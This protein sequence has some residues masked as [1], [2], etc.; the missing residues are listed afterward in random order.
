[1][2]NFIEAIHKGKHMTRS[3]TLK[4]IAQKLNVSVS[5]VSR[6]VNN[7]EYVKEESYVCFKYDSRILHGTG[8]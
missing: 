4:E 1:M 2:Q 8:R 6:A 7:K 3:S 5:T